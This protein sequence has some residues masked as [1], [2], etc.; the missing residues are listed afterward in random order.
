MKKSLKEKKTKL[1]DIFSRPKSDNQK[2]WD[3]IHD[4]YHLV[5]TYMKNN[6]ISQ[7]KL[8]SNLSI[9]RAAVSQMFN[10]T[11]NITVKKMVEIASAIGVNIQFNLDTGELEIKEPNVTVVQTLPFQPDVYKELEA[12]FNSG[13][14]TTITYDYNKLIGIIRKI[15]TMG[16][17]DSVE[18]TGKIK[19]KPSISE[20]LLPTDEYSIYA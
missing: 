1:E 2:A 10:K 20:K 17:T 11:P 4:F 6:N 18:T 16:E 3:L 5:F 13:I 8:A 15:E 9:S 7:S 14:P 12:M 19:E